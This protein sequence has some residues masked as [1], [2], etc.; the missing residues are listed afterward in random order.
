MKFSVKDAPHRYPCIC[1]YLYGRIVTYKKALG[2][3][4]DLPGWTWKGGWYLASRVDK[5]GI[6]VSTLL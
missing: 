3:Q 2:G 4:G 6:T 1:M 5:V